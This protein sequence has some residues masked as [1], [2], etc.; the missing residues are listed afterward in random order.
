MKYLLLSLFFISTVYAS[1]YGKYQ[2][3]ESIETS[4]YFN[5]KSG[6]NTLFIYNINGSVSIEGYDG[7]ALHVRIDKTLMAKNQKNLALAKKEAFF[8]VVDHNNEMHMFMKTPFSSL[9]MKED[10]LHFH[11]SNQQQKYRYKLNYTVKVPR[12]TNLH[13]LAINDGEIVINGI[14]ANLIYA[15]NINGKISL[16]EVSGKMEVMTVNGDVSLNYKDNNIEDGHFKSVNGSFTLGFSEKPDVE[17]AYKTMN[18]HFYTAFDPSDASSFIQE[19]YKQKKQG[20]K[21]KIKNKRRVRIG[22]G[23]HKFYFKTLN[24]DINITQK[25]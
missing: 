17:I 11:E 4:Y 19:E 22:S 24:G 15:K 14:Q 12:N 3:H 25:S 21:F 2:D 7:D 6:D 16:D 23:A 10:E 9:K 20:I 18:G 13:I 1:N 8:K 5:Q